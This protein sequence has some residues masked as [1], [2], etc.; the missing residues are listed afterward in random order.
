MTQSDSAED[1]FARIAFAVVVLAVLA[2]VLIAQFLIGIFVELVSLHR[3]HAGSKTPFGT[4]LR[5]ATGV[6]FV[7]LVVCGVHALVLPTSGASAAVVAA[8]SFLVYVVVVETA[9]FAM[10]AK[11]LSDDLDAYLDW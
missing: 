6:L 8:C 10:G 9:S 5:T 7:I 1:V 3:D 11:A 4:L 2:A